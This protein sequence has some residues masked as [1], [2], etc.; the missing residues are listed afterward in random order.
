MST[1]T[2]LRMIV[3]KQ[4]YEG[5]GNQIAA[6]GLL[7]ALAVNSNHAR[8]PSLLRAGDRCALPARTIYPVGD[9]RGLA[10]AIASRSSLV[11]YRFPDLGNSHG[12]DTLALSI[13]AAR[14]LAGAKGGRRALPG[15]IPAPLFGQAGL[16]GY[17]RNRADSGWSASLRLQPGGLCQASLERPLS[18]PTAN[19]GLV[20]RI[21]IIEVA[22]E[23][24]LLSWNRNHRH[25]ADRRNKRYQQPQII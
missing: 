23:E 4:Y 15:R 12:A 21:L 19:P 5:G 25:D 13:N 2:T 18:E 10:H 11:A 1:C 7:T 8:G 6:G 20:A 3:P 17:F 14:E 9:L 16:S 22:F 24:P